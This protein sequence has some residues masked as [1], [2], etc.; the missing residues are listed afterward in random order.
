MGN[1]EV[2]EKLR[3][4]VIAAE[5]RLYIHH[6]LWL[7]GFGIYAMGSIM[8]VTS[9]G[10][11]PQALLMP[12]EGITLAA[13]AILAPIM[14]GEELTRN[15]II[16]T[17]VII[18]GI[19]ITVSFGP[20]S[21]ESYDSN[22]IVSMF[23][24]VPFLVFLS[25]SIV[26]T[27]FAFIYMHYVRRENKALGIVQDGT[28]DKQGAKVICF[29]YIWIAAIFSSGTMLTAKQTMEL[30]ETTLSGE[31]QFVKPVVWI[32]ITNFLLMNIVME[33][34]KQEALSN[35][36]ALVVVP[37]FQV[38][39]IVLAV[40]AGAI[41][42]DEFSS[43]EMWRV[44]CFMVGIGVV[45]YGIY[46]LATAPR[47]KKERKCISFFTSIY[48]VMI[49]RR[50]KLRLLRPRRMESDYDIIE[51]PKF[52]LEP[53]LGSPPPD[54][55]VVGIE[56]SKHEDASLSKGNKPVWLPPP[57]ITDKDEWL[58]APQRKN[59]QKLAPLPLS[60]RRAS[61]SSVVPLAP[62]QPGWANGLPPLQPL[63]PQQ[64]EQVIVQSPSTAQLD[65]GVLGSRVDRLP[66]MPDS[67]APSTAVGNAKAS[68]GPEF[69]M[70]SP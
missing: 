9:L 59:H 16:S 20:H 30:L 25:F 54:E 36:D 60:P 6:P 52:K 49:V 63:P 64:G 31:D 27:A 21:S 23:L 24:A 33:Y 35:F 50:L 7:W 38:T 66:N 41:Y 37:L 51:P 44:I 19:A 34:W 40:I 67:P 14:L 22:D 62:N 1:K 32:V 39:L 46:I 57:P 61:R 4:D 26:S 12:M 5:Q 69:S 11:G 15:G 8:H 70:V 13:N 53:P 18:L 56:P 47:Q 29:S 2:E 45:C 68:R 10:F 17:S 48:V 55:H 65:L 42:F 58:V 43:M 3:N 28:M